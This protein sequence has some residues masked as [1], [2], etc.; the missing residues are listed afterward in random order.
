MHGY[1]GVDEKYS[2]FD[3]GSFPFDDDDDD[4]V[5]LAAMHT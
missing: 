4:T 2:T 5:A 1:D 3:V